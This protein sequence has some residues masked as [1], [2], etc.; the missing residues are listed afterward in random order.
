V[1]ASLLRSSSES[2][3]TPW[4]TSGLLSGLFHTAKHAC[5]VMCLSPLHRRAL[6]AST[7]G[8][9][10][11]HPFGSE[12]STLRNPVP[13]SWF[14]ATSMV[15]SASGV[16]G[17]LHPAADPGVHRVSVP[18]APM[19]PERPTLS[20]DAGPTL[21][22]NP[23]RKPLCVT[24]DL[25]LLAVLSGS[26]PTLDRFH[27]WRSGSELVG[28]SG[29]SASRPCSVVGSGVS[30]GLLPTPRDPFLPGLLS[31]SRFIFE[32]PGLPCLH[33]SASVASEE[34]KLAS[35]VSH[36]AGLRRSPE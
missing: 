23:R 13:S 5:F 3:R 27:C 24:A 1:R 4:P 14:C 21:R 30:S 29:A 10:A 33:R 26:P 25:A 16:A 32:R 35:S 36:P 22:R 7:P 12:G 19:K 11:C 31:S 9:A 2:Y 6:E 15:S 28:G 8:M 17:L 18:L 34:V 20:R